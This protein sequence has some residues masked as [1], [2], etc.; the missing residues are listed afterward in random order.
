MENIIGQ[1]YR[2]TKQEARPEEKTVKP[3]TKEDAFDILL[4]K[5]YQT[6]GYFRTTTIR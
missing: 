5:R 4:K 6:N 2:A 3:K 1:I